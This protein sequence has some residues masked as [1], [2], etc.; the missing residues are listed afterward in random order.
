[1]IHI[2]GG[3]TV[4]HVRSHFALCAPAYGG[5]ARKLHQMFVS[6]GVPEAC[7]GLELT[8]MADSSSRMETNIDVAARTQALLAV[9]ETKAIIFNA[10]LCDFDGHIGA[11]LSGKYARRLR[12]REG[13]QALVLSPAAKVIQSIKSLRQDVLLVGFKT[14]TNEDVGTQIEFASRQ[15]DETDADFVFANDTVT[16]TNML[17]KKVPTGIEVVCCVTDRE[18]VLQQLVRSVMSQVQT[19][20]G[21]Q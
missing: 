21:A 3:G 18:A 16:R 11:E 17:I 15:I 13:A 9:P 1:M 5:T 4:S 10:A 19:Q 20:A 2:F 6:A 12:S 7:C 8:R 14:T